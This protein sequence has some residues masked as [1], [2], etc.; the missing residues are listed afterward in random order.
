MPRD[1]DVDARRRRV[2]VAV[3]VIVALVLIW[4]FFLRGDGGTPPT[5]ELPEDFDPS[6][7]PSSFG[8]LF[9]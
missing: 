7:I 8:L 9:G 4:L 1:H 2:Q 3:F 6:L 5:G